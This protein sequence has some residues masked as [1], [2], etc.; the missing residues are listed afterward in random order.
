MIENHIVEHF[1]MTFAEK[2]T[3]IGQV[4]GKIAV[5]FWPMIVL[6]VIVAVVLHKQETQ[7]SR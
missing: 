1:D 3:L 4:F 2:I 7:R 6:G 5:N